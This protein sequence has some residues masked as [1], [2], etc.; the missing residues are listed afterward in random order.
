MRSLYLLRIGRRTGRSPHGFCLRKPLL[1]TPV[2]AGKD[3]SQ[4]LGGL[5]G[6]GVGPQDGP[7][8]GLADLAGCARA[9]VEA[10]CDREGH[11]SGG[12]WQ[13]RPPASVNHFYAYGVDST[14][15]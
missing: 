6:R 10:R 14:K 11:G 8:P 9:P 1:I 4:G 3:G 15:K 7:Q 2:N 13:R 12:R 5:D